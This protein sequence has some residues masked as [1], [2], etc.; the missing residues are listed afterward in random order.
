MVVGGLDAW[1]RSLPERRATAADEGQNERTDGVEPWGTPPLHHRKSHFVA[2]PGEM[3]PQNQ[4]VE[5]T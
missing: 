5:D 1:Q 3:T 4:K 2:T